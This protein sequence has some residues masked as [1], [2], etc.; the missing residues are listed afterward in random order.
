MTI[1]TVDLSPSRRGAAHSIVD[2]R[3]VHLNLRSA[4]GEVN[5][6]RGIS[7]DISAGDTVSI[8]GPS[9][10]GKST[11]MMIVGGLESASSGQVQV[12]GHDLSALGEDALAEFRRDNIGI[13]FQAFRLIPTMTAME[14]VAIPLELAGESDAFGQ[15]RE[16]LERVGLAD[17]VQHYPDQLSGG[18]Q[19]RVAIARAFVSKPALLLADEPT[20]NLDRAT[21]DSVVELLFDLQTRHGTTLVL[22]THDETLATRCDR[23]IRMAD[24]LILAEPTSSDTALKS[25]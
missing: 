16:S 3:D 6:L 19:Q 8:V 15:A 13:V 20:G 25:A 17:R 22:I 9:G 24:G 1:G 4:A 7:L 14:N 10:A 12:A 23:I 21:G 18:E 11:L 2:L 5:I